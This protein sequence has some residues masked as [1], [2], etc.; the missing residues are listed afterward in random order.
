MPPTII[1]GSFALKLR[2]ATPKIHVL[3]NANVIRQRVAFIVTKCG[4]SRRVN[5]VKFFKRGDL[6]DVTCVRCRRRS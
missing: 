4:Q 1:V 3:V 6:G 5:E 2:T